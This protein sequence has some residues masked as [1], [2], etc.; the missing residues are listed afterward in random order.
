MTR[1]RLYSTQVAEMEFIPLRHINRKSRGRDSF[2]NENGTCYQ[3]LGM[4][5][6]SWGQRGTRDKWLLQLS[7]QGVMKD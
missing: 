4:E 6:R 2:L 3:K 7:I 1:Y 5:D